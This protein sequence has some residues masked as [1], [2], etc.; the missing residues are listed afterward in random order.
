MFEDWKIDLSKESH[1]K[2][3]LELLQQYSKVKISLRLDGE[4]AKLNAFELP[5]SLL[6]EVKLHAL[7]PLA[8]SFHQNNPNNTH[9][10]AIGLSLLTQNILRQIDIAT[11]DTFVFGSEV[12]YFSSMNIL[13][14]RLLYIL[15]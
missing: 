10:M 11:N 8:I 3:Y 12:P 1:F 6:H 4:D 9:L 14:T 13:F 7:I 2:Q 15:K 5:E